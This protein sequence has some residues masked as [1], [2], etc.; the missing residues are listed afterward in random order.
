MDL[1][2]TKNTKNEVAKRSEII[3]EFEEKNIPS[4]SEVKK[5][6]AAQLNTD[7][8]KIIVSKIDVGY[9][10]NKGTVTVRVYD[11]V[12]TLKEHEPKHQVERNKEEEKE[13][14]EVAEQAT[15]GNTEASEAPKEDNAEKEEATEDV[16][17]DDSKKE[18]IE[19]EAS[20]V[21]EQANESEEKKEE[22]KK[23]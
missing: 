8:T 11:D 9:G 22:E 19:E 7:T 17:D 5:N 4:R 2:I 16:K 6:I 15:E 23:E 13:S 21:A 12:K 20:D 3:A 10:S 14:E 18:V 1:K